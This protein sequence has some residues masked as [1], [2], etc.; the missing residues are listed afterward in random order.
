MLRNMSEGQK[1]KQ[2]KS[3]ETY[4][5]IKFLGRGA[6]GDAY[7]IKSNKTGINYV[8]KIISLENLNEEDI[9][10]VKNE[11]FLL[12]MIDHPNII[13]FKE[14]FQVMKPPQLNLII[15][16]A[17]GGDINK[18]LQEQ[19]PNHFEENLLLDWL[20][21]LCSALG[22]IHDKKI[23][24]R[25]IKPAN[26]FLNNLGQIKLGDFG[27]SKNLTTMKMAHTFTGSLDYLAPEIINGQDYSFEAD[28]WSLGVTFYELMNFRKPFIGNYPSVFLKIINND[29]EPITDFYSKDFRDLIY[30]MLSK[31]PFE[32]PKAKDILKMSFI[33][34]RINSYLKEKKFNVKD[35][36]NLIQNYQRK[37]NRKYFNYNIVK[38]NI[39]NNNTNLNNNDINNKNVSNNNHVNNNDNIVN[40]NN[41]N[42]IRLIENKN[43]NNL[44]NNFNIKY[45]FNISNKN[46]NKN[47]I[48]QRYKLIDDKENINEKTSSKD[49]DKDK[50]NNFLRSMQNPEKRN[51]I[52]LSKN[53]LVNQPIFSN[54]EETKQLKNKD[55]YSSQ[56]MPSKNLKFNNNYRKMNS[57]KEETISL[58]L[59]D[60]KSSSDNDKEKEKYDFHR[61]MNIFSSYINENKTDAQIEEENNMIIKN[62][63]NDN[64]F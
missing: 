35:S 44:N 34:D 61:Q 38:N 13:K 30:K 15:E 18:K 27:V 8:I 43:Y 6:Y 19:A 4:T 20:T 12:K 3:K 40:Y 36:F 10:N 5:V 7:L 17:N 51:K 55:I 42:R 48:N 2:K 47:L 1:K 50:I 49:K 33:K 23:I 16:Y 62:Y 26:I 56:K 46:I 37:K 11:G 14:V 54:Q 31:A 41:N 57:S 29:V 45:K 58:Q 64:L 21:Q 28:I 60:Q 25:D 53:K 9:K 24:H 63:D 39:L 32:R 52:T 22:Y 59:S